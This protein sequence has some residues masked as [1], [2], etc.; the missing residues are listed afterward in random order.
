L[1]SKGLAV[2]KN[3]MQYKIKKI[4][5][6]ASFREFYKI[7][8]NSRFTI[9]VKANKDKFRNLIIYAAINELLIKNKIKAPKLVQENFEKNM[10]EIENLGNYSFLE[11][12]KNKKNKFTDYKKLV[13]LIIKLQKINFKKDIKFR[14]NKI[15]VKKHNLPELHKESDLFFDW[16]LKN[17]SE[18]KELKKNK[19]KIKKELNGLYKKLYFQEM[20]F[21]HRDFHA[22]NIMVKDKKFGLI[23]SQDALR[24]NLLYDVASLIDDVRIKLPIKLKSSLFSY[25]LSKTSK[26]KNDTEKLLAQNDFDILSVQRNLKILGIFV[27][28]FKR[29]HKLSYL[30]YLP[31][32]WELLELRLKNPIFINLKYLL[33]KVVPTKNRKKIKFNDN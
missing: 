29:D 3:L 13:D 19:K 15:R 33:N 4:S 9:L 24:G 28:L 20:C 26:I 12:I 2:G 30:K 11:H 18:K 17:N 8:K 22:S 1:I 31:Y 21:V 7:E 23:D 5:G 16:Y 10:M 32:I 14:N 25:Y 27:R 6:D